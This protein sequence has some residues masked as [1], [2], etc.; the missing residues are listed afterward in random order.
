MNKQELLKQYG[1]EE[2]KI[3]VAKILDKIQFVSQKNQ[4]QTTDF[5]DGHEQKIVQ[6]ILQQARY[7]TAIFYGGY[8]DAE[9]KM[10]YFFPEKLIDL[11]EE[12][13]QNDKMIQKEMKVISI[14]LPNDL[15][16]EYQHRDYLSGLMKLGIKREKVGDIL[17]REN[18]ADILVQE[19]ILNYLLINLPELTRFQKAEI[20]SKEISKL[21]V[22]PI[23]LE[24]M[25]ILVPQ[26]RLDV[27]ISELLHTSRTKV[28]E[29]IAQERV[30][31]NYETK[32]KN[33]TMLQESDL[34]TIRGKGKFKIGEIVSQTAKGKLRVEVEKFFS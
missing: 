34:L 31:V 20:L 16:G 17:V 25:I 6:K 1:K 24:K 18:G 26:L 10:I 15:K 28:N 29:I 22:V 13:L 19:D 7:K 14:H 4:V 12:N 8:E 33:A 5:L 30:L 9:R 3:L 21:E 11:I 32:T 2:D 23:K 27:V